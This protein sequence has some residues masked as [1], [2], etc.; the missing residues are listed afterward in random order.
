[1][2]FHQKGPATVLVVEDNALIQMSAI[3]IIEESGYMVKWA[4]NA[5]DAMALLLQGQIDVL[6]TDIEMPGSMDG[7]ALAHEARRLDPEIEII[8]TS[9]NACP[10]DG[11]MPARCRFLP[12]AYRPEQVGAML[13]TLID[14]A[15]PFVC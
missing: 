12:K 1:M 7:M 5:D 13:R 15:R 6:F 8:I 9:G 2:N 3:M 14:P 4:S 11:A 10:L